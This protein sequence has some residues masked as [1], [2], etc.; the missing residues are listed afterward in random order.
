M[1]HVVAWVNPRPT[2]V[3]HNGNNKPQL[4][5]NLEPALM[6][7][8]SDAMAADIEQMPIQ[9]EQDVVEQIIDIRESHRIAHERALSTLIEHVFSVPEIQRRADEGEASLTELKQ[10]LKRMIEKGFAGENPVG[11]SGSDVF[12]LVPIPCETSYNGCSLA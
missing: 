3:K 2:N 11:A 10:N 8:Y 1:S 6:D 5:K 4:Y 12:S 9:L 7:M